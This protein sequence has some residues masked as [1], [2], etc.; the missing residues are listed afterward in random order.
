M[1][2]LAVVAGLLAMKV[3]ARNDGYI[4]VIKLAYQ[5]D[6]QGRLET[7][8]DVDPHSPDGLPI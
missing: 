3:E 5:L 6:D 2:A 8:Y 1:I 4:C 7:L